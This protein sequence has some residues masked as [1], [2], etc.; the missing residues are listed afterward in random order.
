MHFLGHP[1]P[2]GG[3]TQDAAKWTAGAVQYL[4]LAHAHGE[5]CA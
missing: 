4:E 5:H 2:A 1:A 3:H